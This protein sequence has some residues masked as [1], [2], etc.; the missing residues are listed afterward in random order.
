M[1]RQYLS[2]C[3]KSDGNDSECS[4]T[5]VN[6]EFAERN[7]NNFCVEHIDDPNFNRIINLHVDSVNIYGENEGKTNL[8]IKK[9]NK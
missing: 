4:E 3:E 1:L 6:S 5:T 9:V 7:V 8:K 2:D